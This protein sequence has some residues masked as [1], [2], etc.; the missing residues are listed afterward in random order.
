MAARPTTPAKVNL[1]RYKAPDYITSRT[2]TRWAAEYR[3]RELAWHALLEVS[4]ARLGKMQ[5]ELSVEALQGQPWVSGLSE[6]LLTCMKP[7]FA[8]KSGHLANAP[9]AL[10]SAMAALKAY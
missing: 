6:S 9:K 8:K 7:V 1:L 3:L 4:K 2:A 10:G 5:A